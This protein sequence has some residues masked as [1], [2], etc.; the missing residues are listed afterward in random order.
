MAFLSYFIACFS[1][2]F[3]S[4]ASSFILIFFFFFFLCGEDFYRFD[5]AHSL[6]YD[7]DHD[8]KNYE[9]PFISCRVRS[10]SC[11]T[12]Y[13]YFP[14]EKFKKDFRYTQHIFFFSFVMSP[15][16]WLTDLTN[17]M[18]RIW[19]NYH[20]ITSKLYLFGTKLYDLVLHK[21][22]QKNSFIPKAT[23]AAAMRNI[24]CFQKSKID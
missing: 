23:T 13:S 22:R 21:R 9:N 1:C 15:A 24:F 14:R 2:S 7:D 18:I 4:F 12:W 11:F 6:F 20:Q 5:A 19:L 3:R 16:D 10:F 8:E 17:Y